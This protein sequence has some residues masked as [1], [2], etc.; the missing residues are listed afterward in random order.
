M[1]P[2]LLK[3]I[4]NLILHLKYLTQLNAFRVGRT[5]HVLFCGRLPEGWKVGIPFEILPHILEKNKSSYFPRP[6]QSYHRTYRESKP[7]PGFTPSSYADPGR[8]EFNLS[9]GEPRC[10]H[11]PWL[12]LRYNADPLQA[13]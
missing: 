12:N 2:F 9:T 13:I 3:F 7:A 6:D 5:L 11:C 4:Q 10:A 1:V 8:L